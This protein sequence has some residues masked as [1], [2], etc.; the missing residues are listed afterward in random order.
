MAELSVNGVKLHVQRLGQGPRTA[1]FVHGLVMD[2][3]SSWYF[4][5]A[6]QLGGWGEAILFDLRG[7][8]RSQRP[9]QGYS[10]GDFD[11][12][13]L[14]V[15]AL[16]PAGSPVHL[17]GNSFGGL[18]ALAFA[19]KHPERVASLALVDPLLGRPG[20]GKRMAETLGL[21]GGERDRRIEQDFR[22][23]LGRHSDRRRTRL[24]ET[25]QA[26]IEETTLIADL[27]AGAPLAEEALQKLSCPVLALFGEKSDVLPDAAHLRQAVPHA[28]VLVRDGCT[29]SLLWEATPWV[30]DTVIAWLG[31][32]R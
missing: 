20:W 2:N 4:T 19:A 32:H 9:A 15:A 12:D 26:L 30:R 31:E 3:L 6:T 1:V 25:A 27:R 28:R 18:L 7:H 23:W 13:L 24:A 22:N 5:V 29:H 14:A 16:A 10:L 8:G 21:K 11:S 17:I